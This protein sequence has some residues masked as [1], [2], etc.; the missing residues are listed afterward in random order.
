M[1]FLKMNLIVVTIVVALT[2]GFVFGLLIPGSRDIEK[3]RGEV[4]EEVAAVRAD[5]QRV[6]NVSELYASIMEMDERMRDFRKRLPADRQFGEFLND[7]SENLKKSDINDYVVQPRRA[8]RLDETRLPETLQLA[9][10]TIILPVRLSFETS[11]TKLFEFLKNVEALPRLFHV[12]DVKVVNDEVQPGEV[13]VEIL[14]HTY[15]YPE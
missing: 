15:H 7:L 8:L 14:L 1:N 4:A 3:V 5:Q 9:K 12:E 6:G 11:F 13:R 2:A 10:G